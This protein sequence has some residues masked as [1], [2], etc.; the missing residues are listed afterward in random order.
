MGG[1]IIAYHQITKFAEELAISMKNTAVKDLILNVDQAYWQVVSL[2]YKKQMADSYLALLEKL[3]QDVDAMYE[4]G[5]AYGCR[6][7]E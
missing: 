6:K 7:T 2:V 1:K 3:T 5:V 4:V